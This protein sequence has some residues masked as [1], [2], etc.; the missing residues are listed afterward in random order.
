[1]LEISKTLNCEEEAIHLCGKVQNFGYLLIFNSLGEC[2]ALSENCTEWLKLDIP[3]ALAKKLNY[4]IDLLNK[5]NGLG[6][7]A[8]ELF[9]LEDRI[10]SY[11]TLL[12]NENYQ[13]T[14]YL[15][16]NQLFLEFEKNESILIELSQLNDFQM[17]FDQ[18]EN[19]WKSL[20]D[21]IMKIIDFDRIMIYQFLEDSSGI[22]VAENIKQQGESL[23]GYRY[24]EFDIPVQA[25]QLYLK[26]LSRQ[27]PD[28]EAKTYDLHGI[29]A[30]QIDLSKSQI[31]ALSPIHLQY[32]KNFGVSA[33]ASFSIIIDNK[34]WGLVA[35]QNFQPKYIPY[36]K[37]SLCVFVTHYAANKYLVQRQRIK[38]RQN[39]TI[40][41]IE[42]GL[43]EKL[44]YN[45]SF[46]KTLDEFAHQFMHTLSS[47]GLIIKSPDYTLR[48]GDTPNNQL[49]KKIHQE[50]NV[51][52][53]DENIYSSFAFNLSEE[54]DLSK[55]KGIARISFDNEHEY[56]IYWFR[57]E[58]LIEEKWAGVPEKLPIFSEAKNAY[59]YSPRTSFQV[60]KKEVNGQS[61]KW[62]KFDMEFLSRI[63]K[64]I[65]DSLLRQMTE[66]KRLNEKLIETNNQLETYTQELGHDLKNPLSTIKTSAQFMQTRKDLPADMIVKFSKN[67]TEAAKVINDIIDRTLAS[68]KSSPLLFQLEVIHTEGF[69][70][71]IITQAI[72]Y[73]KV[74][75]MDLRLGE[76]YP[77]YGE[78]TSLYQLFMNLINN[79]IKFSSQQEATILEVYSEI[80]ENK[81]IYYIKDNGIG[82]DESEKE[83]V[84]GLFK[85]LTNASAY[86]GSGVGMSIV[87]RILD[88][89]NAEISF[90]SNLGKGTTF[91]ISFP[92]E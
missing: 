67:I 60:W 45:Q 42:L 47:S 90:E 7:N 55:W 79:A 77:I 33:S 58:I 31:R 44:F 65:Q 25:R 39:E 27:T 15:N 26:N 5:E 87:R 70:N 21:N 14:V 56:A 62:S 18:S 75:N 57:K 30:T 22:V 64:L 41:E 48:Y 37:R 92:N 66:V 88:R 53:A 9:E 8:S 59:V 35:C 43:K 36:D 10:L 83:Q 73:Y 76:L 89:L 38:M 80:K 82:I 91:K 17:I 11:K 69:I 1:M 46:E 24:P 74:A 52:A 40:K 51:Q 16:N 85:R 54:E 28:I 63:H 81:T 50:V 78:K 86:E 29:S 12:K 20:C 61:E 6:I 71:Q 68:A 72:E 4:Y 49:F 34:L 13:L 84:F 3:T 19:M 32:L 23:I 2:L